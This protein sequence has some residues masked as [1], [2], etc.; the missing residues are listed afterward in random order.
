MVMD[1]DRVRADLA[2]LSRSLFRDSRNLTETTKVVE[3][4]ITSFNSK[5]PDKAIDVE[6]MSM[7][8]NRSCQQC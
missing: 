4:M 7:F 8:Y 1:A 2:A 6:L 3:D 5:F